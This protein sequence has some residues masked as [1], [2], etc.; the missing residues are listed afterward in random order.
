[1]T[2]LFY[3][4]I[5]FRCKDIESLASE[6]YR[7]GHHVMLLSQAESGSLHDSFRLMGLR[8]D[9][10]IVSARYQFSWF[11]I[12]TLK[13]LLYCKK[14]RVDLLFS[15]LEPTNLPAVLAQYFIKTRV[16]I[17]RHHV[18][19][20]KIKNFEHSWSYR[21]TYSLAKEIISVSA[22][23][24]SYMM[25]EERVPKHK[26]S[27]IELG[28]NFSL[29]GKPD[30]GKIEAIKNAAQHSLILVTAGALESYKRPELSIEIL[31]RAKVKGV[32]CRLIFLGKGSLEQGLRQ[33]VM[34]MGM[35]NQVHFTGFVESVMDYLWA[36]D[37]LIH[38]SIS[39]SSCV[40]V[41]EAAYAELPVMVC[42]NVGDFD[43]YMLH[44]VNGV[45]LDRGDFV[46]HAVYHLEKYHL[47]REKYRQMG[48]QLKPEIVKRFSID[49]VFAKYANFTKNG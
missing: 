36:A 41:K 30:Y 24:K 32:D 28:Y 10:E 22:A 48:K 27:V 34:Q 7:Q 31:R 35:D 37:W 6:F 20:A 11:V 3:T 2:I 17:Y 19:L 33:K 13:L 8:A 44:E 14:N 46:E 38:P 47:S 42:R 40:V 16:V 25:K 43:D 21:L 12:T 4:P 18:D 5:N 39:E 1:M 26:I 49:Q 45:V 15:H 23:G 9:S 29:F